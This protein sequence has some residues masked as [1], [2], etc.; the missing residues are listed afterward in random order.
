MK[1]HLRFFTTLLLLSLLVVFGYVNWKLYDQ[2]EYRVMGNDTINHDLLCQLRHL[3][4]AIANNA[5][6][7]MQNVYPEGYVFFNALYG[8][9]WTDFASSLD[10]QSILYQEAH[11]EIQ[12][13]YNHI[14]SEH[15]RSSFDE[16]LPLKYGAF[17]TG[18]STYLLGRKLEAELPEKRLAVEVLAFEESC[19]LIAQ[20]LQAETYPASYYG[21]AWPADAIMC[22]AALAAHDRMFTPNY[23]TS[24]QDWISKVKTLTDQDGLIPHSVH[25]VTGEALQPARGSS[26]SL[27]LCFLKEIDRDFAKGQFAIYDALFYDMRV[28]LPG[29]LEFPTG[30]SGESD[31]DSGPVFWGM[32][33]A[34]IITGMRTMAEYG[35]QETAMAMRNTIEALSFPKKNEGK[36]KYFLGKQ[37]MADA[38]IAW[39]HTSLD[40]ASKQNVPSGWRRNFQLFSLLIGMP[41]L[42]AVFW[43]WKEK[44]RFRFLL[45]PGK[46]WKAFFK[47]AR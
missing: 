15:A 19:N 2:P 46:R 13:A 27:M 40:T 5:A 9:A 12:R 39:A 20:R 47:R 23:S 30:K 31:V 25:A 14:A 17:Y 16:S 21:S 35:K 44:L 10:R 22:A 32:G 37:P 24:L 45:N 7:D 38:F 42:A 1:R 29:I 11:V 8:L 33:G 26:Q 4:D 36:K 28:G 34:S 18:W 41:S 43:M 3:R 6:N